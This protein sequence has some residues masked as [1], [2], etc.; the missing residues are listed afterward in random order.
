VLLVVMPWLAAGVIIGMLVLFLWP[1][2][3]I[4]LLSYAYL[5]A[6]A[7]EA[8]TSVLARVLGFVSLTAGL[9][10]TEWSALATSDAMARTMVAASR[11][12][13]LPLDLTLARLS[14]PIGVA[15]FFFGLVLIRRS[16]RTSTLLETLAVASI[17]PATALLMK[18]DLLPL[19]T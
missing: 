17:A 5:T 10:A 18:L 9:I 13:S 14:W 1:V 6:R 4:S 8:S 3:L 15:L 16:A 19:T 11:G 7:P 12:R 2:A